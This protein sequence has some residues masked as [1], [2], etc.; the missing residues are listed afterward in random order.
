MSPTPDLIAVI[1]R[2]MEQLQELADTLDHEGG[3]YAKA[4]AEHLVTSRGRGVGPKRPA[5]LPREAGALIRDLVLDSY[6]DV[7]LYGSPA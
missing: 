2:S 6:A 3:A 7:H 4:Y 1:A 5:A